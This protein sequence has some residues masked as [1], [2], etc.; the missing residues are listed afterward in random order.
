MNEGVNITYQNLGYTNKTEIKEKFIAD[1]TYIKKL[2]RHQINASQLSRKT[3]ARQIQVSRNKEI[4]TIRK[5]VN[6]I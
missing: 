4:I 5:V 3:T 6:K 2:E 1:S